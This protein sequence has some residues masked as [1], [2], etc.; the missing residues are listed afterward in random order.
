MNHFTLFQSKFHAKKT[1]TILL[2]FSLKVFPDGKP[3]LK[4]GE[5]LVGDNKYFC[6]PCSKKVETL[7]RCC[8]KTL[9][10]TLLVHLK[11]F[12]FD[13]EKM[14]HIKLNDMCEF[15]MTLNMEPYTREGRIFFK[16][17]SFWFH[18]KIRT[19]SI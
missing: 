11:R 3:V 4:I 7:K 9:P 16:E 13:Y 2:L 19:N 15:P 17:I 14:K 1:F 12:E 6:E 5:M 10:N 8:I 18:E